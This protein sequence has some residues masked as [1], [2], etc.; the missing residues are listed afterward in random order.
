MKQFPSLKDPT[1]KQKL[2]LQ[3]II[4]KMPEQISA[5]KKIEKLNKSRNK[6][7]SE[8]NYSSLMGIE[9]VKDEEQR[10][11]L[12]CTWLPSRKNMLSEFS[13]G[14]YR[15]HLKLSSGQSEKNSRLLSR[16]YGQSINN[17]E[18]YT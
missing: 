5:Y 13:R 3:T 7:N 1:N 12:I 2:T 9:E 8:Y 17:E 11:P 15:N 14:K 16:V 18:A 4:N 6:S 10:S